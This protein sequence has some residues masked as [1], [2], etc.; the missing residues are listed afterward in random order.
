MRDG[1]P[2][3]WFDCEWLPTSDDG[4]RWFNE[5]LE[6]PPALKPTYDRLKAQDDA[7]RAAVGLAPE[8]HWASFAPS[9]RD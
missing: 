8:P 1:T 6:L 4:P 3:Q 9:S 7:N 2:H 5:P